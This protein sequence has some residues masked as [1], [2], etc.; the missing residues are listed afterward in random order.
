MQCWYDQR[1]GPCHGRHAVH[2]CVIDLHMISFPFLKRE[3]WKAKKQNRYTMP[4]SCMPSRFE[5]DFSWSTTALIFSFLSLITGYGVRVRPAAGNRSHGTNSHASRH[6]SRR[7]A[8]WQNTEAARRRH[9]CRPRLPSARQALA[10]EAGHVRGEHGAAR[11][12]AA[13]TSWGEPM[14]RHS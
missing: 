14:R 9:T 13:C 2:G 5:K 8:S 4:S 6:P 11:V 10:G 3:K 12:A 7:S 1:A